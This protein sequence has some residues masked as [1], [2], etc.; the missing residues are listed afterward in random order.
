MKVSTQCKCQE[1]GNDPDLTIKNV[2][3]VFE[4][5][6]LSLFIFVVAFV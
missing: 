1:A 3:L 5:F 2:F 4:L 6:V